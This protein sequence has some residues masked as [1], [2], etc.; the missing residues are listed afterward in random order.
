MEHLCGVLAM[1][2]AYAKHLECL[3]R[4]GVKSIEV[5]SLEDLYRCER[6]ILPGG[7]STTMYR[8]LRQARLWQPLIRC[9]E[10][11]M[12]MFGTSAGMILLS[13]GI[14]GIGQ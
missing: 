1:Q 14:S 12:P 10:E 5:R 11:G 6:L 13:R 9:S 4:L 7:E 3:A 2:G 8:L